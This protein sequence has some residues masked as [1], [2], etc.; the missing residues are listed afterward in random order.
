MHRFFCHSK[1][2]FKVGLS[3]YLITFLSKTKQ[4]EKTIGLSSGHPT[5]CG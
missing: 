3:L 1:A 5:L 4:H 2:S